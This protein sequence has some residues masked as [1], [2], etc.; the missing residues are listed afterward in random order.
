MIS[1][2]LITYNGEKYINEQLDSILCQLSA[3]DEVVVSDD[4]S[5][6]RTL[7]II[8]DYNDNRLRIISNSGK[9]GVVYN[10]EN[11]LR[12][13]KGDYIFLADQDDVWL[14]GKV[15]TTM[16]A[17][18]DSHLVISD[19]YVT[20]ENLNTV[21]RSFYKVNKSSFT[22]WLAFLRNPYLGC[23]MAF[24]KDILHKVLPFPANTP[25]HDIWIGNIAAFFYTVKFI[26]DKLIYY[27]RH[28]ANA[29]TTSG[30]SKTTLIQK[31][32]YRYNLMT[33]LLKK[34]DHKLY[35]KNN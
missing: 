29:S 16:A 4:G 12:E 19:C 13:V 1:I 26:P 33:G 3:D 32:N 23:C 35:P 2:C 30:P 7:S 11:A 20:D 22:K 24:K 10:V 5:T 34:C 27:R 21:H 25:M 14:P 8:R 15:E 17:L 18:A 28:D 6:D 31:F 9:H